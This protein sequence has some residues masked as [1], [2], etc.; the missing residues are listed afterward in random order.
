[1]TLIPATTHAQ[2]L[3]PSKNGTSEFDPV[4]MEKL[5]DWYAPRPTKLQRPVVVLDPFAGTVCTHAH[6]LARIRMHACMNA[7]MRTPGGVVRGFV[8]AAMGMLYIGV[9]VSERQVQANRVQVPPG[10]W[11]FRHPPT[12]L[13]GDGEDVVSLVMV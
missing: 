9:D 8:S 5:L 12:W 2:S 7:H 3:M 11:D 6:V 1:M 10:K 13:V 4:L